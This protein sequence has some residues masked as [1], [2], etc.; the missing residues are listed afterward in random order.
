MKKFILF[1]VVLGIIAACGGY[2]YINRFEE[3]TDDAQINGDIVTLAP[4][5]SGYV[6]ALTIDDNQRVKTGDVLLEIDP[7]DYIARR[8]H[9]Q[10]ALDAAKAAA[11][12]AQNNADTTNVSAPSNLVAAQA[13]VDAAQANWERATSDLKR[14]QKLGRDA[15]SQTQLDQAIDAEKTAHS[16][17][18]AANARLRSAQTAP[19][20]IAQAQANSDSL[21]AQVKEAE[22]TLA[23][24]ENDLAHTKI[25]APIDGRIT[26]RSVELGNYV[27]PGQALATLVGNDMWVVANFKETQL[28]RMRKGQPVT[29]SLDAYPDLKLTGK[30]DSIQSG[31]G[32]YFSAFPPE[33]ATGNFVKIVQRVPVK[34]TFDHAPDATLALGPGMSVVPTVDTAEK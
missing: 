9:A 28:T 24:A 33:N 31:T 5:V 4:Q 20:T 2:L 13:Q 34:I 27:Q 25:V 22:A 8:D 12:A 7:A 10:A 6:S 23:Q 21:A 14:M 15:R 16:N 19:K 1:A 26:G 18:D 3:S 29:L 17:L 30:V 11:E 32:S